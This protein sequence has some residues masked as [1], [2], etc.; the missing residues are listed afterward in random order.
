[1]WV[2]ECCSVLLIFLL[3]WSLTSSK[4]SPL[5]FSSLLSFK[6]LDSAKVLFFNE[7]DSSKRILVSPWSRVSPNHQGTKCFSNLGVCL[8]VCPFF[9][10]HSI[11]ISL[12]GC[13]MLAK[14]QSHICIY[15]SL[16]CCHLHIIAHLHPSITSREIDPLTSLFKLLALTSC[17]FNLHF[18]N[19]TFNTWACF[20]L[21][22]CQIIIFGPC[23]TKNDPRQY[24]VIR[25]NPW[26][27]SSYFIRC[28]HFSNTHIFKEIRV[29]VALFPLCW[30]LCMGPLL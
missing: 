23:G 25:L 12:H 30:S 22:K 27:R 10:M 6:D 21:H 11:F 5:F 16:H 8:L 2:V 9:W 4:E 7:L 19:D 17:C 28:E 26:K 29:F 24:I 13:L 1:M 20:S 14:L 3:H 18:N 15:C